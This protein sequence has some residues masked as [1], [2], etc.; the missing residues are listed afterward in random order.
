M[1]PVVDICQRSSELRRIRARFRDRSR[2]RSVAGSDRRPHKPLPALGMMLQRCRDRCETT[3]PTETSVMVISGRW[4]P[5]G[6]EF[7]AEKQ[8]GARSKRTPRN[9]LTA[10]RPES[11]IP[12]TSRCSVSAISRNRA[13]ALASSWRIRSFVTPSLAPTCSRVCGAAPSLKPYRAMMI[14]RSRG[15]S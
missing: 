5:D 2:L 15:V 9:C 11:Q 8:S 4:I 1:R 10:R 14:S 7:M 3:K 13:K 12:G 6:D